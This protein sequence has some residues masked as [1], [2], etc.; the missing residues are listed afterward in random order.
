MEDQLKKVEISDRIFKLFALLIAALIINMA[1]GLIFRA[2]DRNPPR[3]MTFTG[4]GKVVVKS[5]VAKISFGYNASGS[6]AGALIDQGSKKIS[7]AVEAIK[8][9]GVE[10]ADIKT[11]RYSLTPQYNAYGQPSGYIFEE[12]FEIKV[13]DFEKIEEILGAGTQAGLNMIGGITFAQGD[14][15]VALSEARN[16]AIDNA[17]KKAEATVPKL[18]LK[19]GKVMYMY[20]EQFPVY[21]EERAMKAGAPLEYRLPT[22]EPGQEEVTVRVNVSYRVK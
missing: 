12:S 8:K 21:A 9:L 11:T 17:R 3:D 13:K 7:A 5:D 16:L 2:M 22:I 20:E 14:P 19:L 15:E 6:N 10:E 1:L 4:E 18:G